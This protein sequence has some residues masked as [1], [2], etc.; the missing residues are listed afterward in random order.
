[1]SAQLRPHRRTQGAVKATR[2]FFEP[3]TTSSKLPPSRTLA[4]GGGGGLMLDLTLACSWTKATS[5][6]RSRPEEYSSGSVEPAGN[7]LSAAVSCSKQDRNA[8]GRTGVALD[9]E[10]RAEVAADTVGVSLG[11]DHLVGGE[12]VRKLLIDRS[13]W[14]LVTAWADR[15]D[16][17]FLQCPHQ[18]LG[19]HYRFA[20]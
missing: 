10:A 18:L 15:K 2:T 17:R 19:Q 11:D 16:L 5:A 4:A 20:W 7:H 9:V 8:D 13:N 14:L 3:S 12:G 1:M 6:S